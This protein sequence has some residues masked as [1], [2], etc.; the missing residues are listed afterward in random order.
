MRG[1]RTEDIELLIEQNEDGF[2]VKSIFDKWKD[3]TEM[4]LIHGIAKTKEDAEKI[5]EEIKKARKEYFEY[6]KSFCEKY[7][8]KSIKGKE[9]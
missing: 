6:E 5:I 3:G 2:V 1:G 9:G 4:H 8:I 7:G